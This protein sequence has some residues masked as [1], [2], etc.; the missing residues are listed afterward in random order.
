MNTRTK[1]TIAASVAILLAGV[2][3]AGISH[4]DSYGWG[5][6]D[7]H[8]GG[9]H[10]RHGADRD[11]RWGMG[12]HGGH[13]GGRYMLRMFESYDSN[14]D[15]KLTQAEIDGVRAA[16]LTQFD[17]DG[18][19]SLSLTEYQGLWMDAMR[20]RMVDRF[21]DLDDDGDGMVTKDEFAKPFARVVRYM[22]FNDDG[23]IG[24]EDMGRHHRGRDRDDN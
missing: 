18:D 13:H 15:G 1:V 4:A 7:S 17:T 24:R 2:G 20:E 6:R 21:Q 8:Y 11:G 10:Y 9:E 19:G 14:G 16:R 22:D 12:G 23:A 3:V 5:H